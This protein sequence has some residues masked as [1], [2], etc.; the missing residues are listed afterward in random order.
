VELGA[1]LVTRRDAA[2]S[3]GCTRYRCA[4]GGGVAKSIWFIQVCLGFSQSV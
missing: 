1:L 2:V 3:V 4:L